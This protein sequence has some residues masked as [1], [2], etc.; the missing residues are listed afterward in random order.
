MGIVESNMCVNLAML[1]T[2]VWEQLQAEDFT[3]QR[4]SKKSGGAKAEE[5]GW[6]IQQKPHSG[7]C[8]GYKPGVGPT[9]DAKLGD[10]VATKYQ[11]D[12]ARGEFVWR[13]FMNNG[14]QAVSTKNHRHACGWR[15]CDPAVRT[16]WP[17]RCKTPLEKESWWKWFDA[18]LESLPIWSEVVQKRMVGGGNSPRSRRISEQ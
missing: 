7:S 16:L 5:S 14:Y 11:K 9:A 15:K 1:P 13:V 12:S 3:V 8:T 2:E 18:Q 4:N 6:R 10:A 17:T